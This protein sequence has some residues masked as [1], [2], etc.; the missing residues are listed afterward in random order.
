MYKSGPCIFPTWWRRHRR[1][2]WGLWDRTSWSPFYSGEKINL[3]ISLTNA[4]F[5]IFTKM[6]GYLSLAEQNI[7]HINPIEHHLGQFGSSQT[8]NSGENI[9]GT[10]HFM[11]DTY[12]KAAVNNAV[13]APCLN[14]D[15][16]TSLNRKWVK[17]MLNENC[18]SKTDTSRPDQKCK[19]YGI[20][21]LVEWA[22]ASRQWP[23]LSC[24]PHT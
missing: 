14:L 21:D 12:R 4:S 3:T 8:C 2:H 17:T 5:Q 23:A 16:S 9:Q 10:G 11:G 13:V 15:K 6:Y 1:S 22:P 19:F 20:P 7:W 24:P 18:Q